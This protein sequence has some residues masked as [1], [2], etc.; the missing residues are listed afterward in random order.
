MAHGYA[1]YSNPYKEGTGLSGYIAGK[2]G[3]AAKM[4][5]DERQARDEEVK[6]LQEKE[7]LTDEEQERL[8]FLTEQQG[9]RKGSFFFKSMMS[10]FGGDR[11]RRLKGT[12]SKDP[13]AANDPAL[14]KEERFSALLDKDKP[15]EAPVDP[16]TP[17]QPTIPGLESATGE[18][19]TPN[20][21]ERAFD[22]VAK[23]YDSIA[24]RVSALASEEKQSVSSD[25]YNNRFLSNITASLQ[26]IKEYF[27]KDNDLKEEEND[28]E[29]G[30]LELALDRQ[31]NAKMSEKA[32]A[33]SAT[34]DL[35]GVSAVEGEPGSKVA[36]GGP[37]S[38]VGNLLKNIKGLLGGKG[39]AGKTQYSNPIGPQPMN[40]PT[41]W[42]AKG[43]GDAGGMFGQ[44][45]FT[46]RMPA[47]PI[48]PMSEG[49]II[50]GKKPTKL[51]GGGIVDNPTVTK[52]NP[53]DSVV[54]LNRNNG[55][56]KMFKAAG[57]GSAG[58]DIT[59]PMAKVMQLP[60]QVGGG[61]L[62][63]LLSDVMKKVMSGLGPIGDMIKPI[64]NP[65]AAPLAG[66]FGLPATIVSAMFGGS[67]QAATFDPS[68]YFDGES[69]S[70]T[71]GD[72]TGPS[73]T[74]PAGG[75]GADLGASMRAGETI[76]AQ[77][78]NGPGG[79]IQGGSGKG[80]EGGQNTNQGYAT[81]YHLTPP[82]NDAAGWA[83]SRAVAFTSAKMMLAR[84]S[85]IHFGNVVRDVTPG[86]SDAELQSIIAA[87]Q[88]AHTKPGRTQGGIDMQESQNGNMR[89][90][91]PLKVT[92][93][94]NDISGGAGR[95]ARIIGTNVRLAHGAA[96]SANSVESAAMPIATN[97]PPVA[98]PGSDPRAAA[99][100]PLLTPQA[101][102]PGT[103]PQNPFVTLMLQQAAANQAKTKTDL[104]SNP[105][106]SVN[107][108]SGV[109]SLY[110]WSY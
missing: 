79:F 4:A 77:D 25:S 54:P 90:K 109:S 35:S 70:K 1:S 13:S 72:G 8:D 41:P 29:Q 27:S 3:S 85:K 80:S 53:G 91:F 65:L 51:A 46:P 45:G 62:L 48:K 2:I 58:K 81:H 24:D 23:S 93:V 40:S 105:M 97:Q 96:G 75:G 26:A 55:M 12:F 68:K 76:Q 17:Y 20:I 94:T 15:T 92:N 73:T 107:N 104:S 10:E 47:A 28:I 63:G 110:Q 34:E 67:A 21:L 16:D 30:Q 43:P 59:D 99:A 60:T 87:E 14:T 37:L 95:T 11:A 32:D 88:Q 9:G 78:P 52:L 19:K 6:A 102:P 39:R 57:Q 56:G 106:F 86:I 82:S 42:A 100:N 61:L 71:G 49:G 50:P 69:E 103:P 38:M 5:R 31:E 83:Q 44:G 66:A 108:P 18:E 84:G 101:T 22:K 64:I 36:E 98:L 7:E 89:L 33:M 74:P